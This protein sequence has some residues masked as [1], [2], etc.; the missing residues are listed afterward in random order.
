MV[1]LIAL[2]HAVPVFV[3]AALTG[4]KTAIFFTAV[5]MGIVGLFTGSPAYLFVDVIAVTFAAWV[6]MTNITSSPNKKQS[7]VGIFFTGMLKDGISIVVTLGLVFV[8]LLGAI[9]G[10]NRFYGDCA[11]TKLVAMGLTWEQ[12]RDIYRKKG[13]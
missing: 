3:L 1:L 11:D 12:C 7:E 10:Y 4:N 8:V 13:R 6:C 9:M 5:L 2:L